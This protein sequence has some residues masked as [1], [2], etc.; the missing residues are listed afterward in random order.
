MA[1]GRGCAATS[2]SQGDRAIPRADAQVD[3]ARGTTSS[4]CNRRLG[5]RP[6]VR[7][8]HADDDIGV[9]FAATLTFIEHRVGLA[10]AGR[11]AEVD[12]QQA[13][14]HSTIVPPDGD[15]RRGH[16]RASGDRW[17]SVVL[18]G[19]FGCGGRGEDLVL[20]V[21]DRR[22]RVVPSGRAGH[23]HDGART[24]P[25]ELPTSEPHDRDAARLVGELAL[26]ARCA[27]PRLHA[28]RSHPTGDSGALAVFE[29]VDVGAVGRAAR[30]C[31]CAARRCR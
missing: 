6:V 10:D 2:S 29:V 28:Q 15:G 31:R 16:R 7:L 8:D 12:A 30:W 26:E 3:A 5:L 17:R 13:T 23:R 24:Y 14:C 22:H 11:R 1:R 25:G 4:S 9:P 18:G 27:A 20:R 21:E 19:S